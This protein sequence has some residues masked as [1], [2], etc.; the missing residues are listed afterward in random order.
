MGIIKDNL[1]KV[2]ERIENAAVHAGRSAS[3]I[4]L[5]AVSKTKTI[6]DIIEAYEA[7]QRCFGENYAQELKIKHEQLTAY[8]IEWHFIGHL[9]KNKTKIVAPIVSWIESIDSME[10]AETL[11]RRLT[12]PIN[13]LIEVNLGQEKSKTGIESDKLEALV[14]NINGLKNINL[15]GLMIIP[16]FSS[17]PE[18][19]RLYFSELRKLLNQLNEKRIAKEPL[20]ELSMG[21]SHDF[22]IA[23]QE[24]ATI[25]RIGT[26]I[27][28]ERK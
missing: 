7:G 16:P 15:K 14:Y 13:C 19:S 22:E 21:M 3:S 20:S 18:E 2:K 27:F 10:L 9:Q 11:E 5:V 24:G 1:E 28:G 26:A 17:N 23:I 12:N 25:L 4:K 6:E 8:D